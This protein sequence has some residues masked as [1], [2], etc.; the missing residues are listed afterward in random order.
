MNF[1]TALRLPAAFVLLF[2]L[3]A[4]AGA[5]IPEF[6]GAAVAGAPAPFDYGATVT[7]D[8][9]AIEEGEGF[10]RTSRQMFDAYLAHERIGGIGAMIARRRFAK[11]APWNLEFA[12]AHA[13]SLTLSFDKRNI[14]G[15]KRFAQRTDF[16]Y[17]GRKVTVYR[18][19]DGLQ[20]ASS[21]FIDGK[22]SLGEDG[23]P[24]QF[25]TKDRASFDGFVK[26]FEGELGEPEPRA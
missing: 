3:A 16:N 12:R 17:N 4:A 5:D 6:E 11:V 22:E 18:Y 13:D 7:I 20:S 24:R 19:R 10:A 15:K 2:S 21:I 26:W 25:F 23:E 9:K 14:A 8:R 1:S